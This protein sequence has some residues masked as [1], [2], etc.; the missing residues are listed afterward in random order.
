MWVALWRPVPV[1]DSCT[2]VPPPPVPAPGYSMITE[3]RGAN[4][5][6]HFYRK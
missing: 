4:V 3:I 5:I 1:P 2:I 6:Y